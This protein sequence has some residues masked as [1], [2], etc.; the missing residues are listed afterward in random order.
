LLWSLELQQTHISLSIF[1]IVYCNLLEPCWKNNNIALIQIDV[2]K[3]DFGNENNMDKNQHICTT[4]AQLKD[5]KKKEPFFGAL[6]SI[7]LAGFHQAW[8][9]QILHRHARFHPLTASCGYEQPPRVSGEIDIKGVADETGPA[10]IGVATTTL[11]GVP[12]PPV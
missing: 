3:S 2:R 12:I 8:S 7:W 1:E 4:L 9:F 10:A 6:V 11:G 5:T